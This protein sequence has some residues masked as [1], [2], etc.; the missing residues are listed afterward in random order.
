[1]KNVRSR[2]KQ[3]VTLGRLAF[4]AGVLGWLVVGGAGC[5][6]ES[7]QGSDTSGPTA[8]DVPG[9]RSFEVTGVIR[10]IPKEGGTLLVRHEAIPGYM[11]KMTMEL[12]LLNTQ[13]VA[14]LA[15]GDTIAFRLVARAEDHFIDRVRRMGPPA[16]ATAVA[17]E[18]KPGT[19][20][21]PV[22]PGGA[23]L[24]P[25]DPV[26][27]IAFRLETGE[28]VQISKWRGKAV[29][30]TFIFT[31]CPLPDFCPRMNRNFQEARELLA[32]TAGAPTHWMFLSLSFDSDFDQPAVLK[33]YASQYRETGVEG[34]LF[35]VLGP[36]GVAMVKPAFDLMIGREAGGFSHNLRTV[37]VDPAGKVFR[38]FDGNR[39]TPQDLATAMTEA[40]QVGVPTPAPSGS[41]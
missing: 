22:V 6:P 9:E 13:E 41:L 36:S 40:C 16:A 24:K 25:G 1:M 20:A 34:W 19:E 15:V 12:S 18:T 31:R 33:T 10:E 23:A 30:L 32:S 39:W 29:A 21:V 28:V 11:P 3:A 8:P 26:P 5:G 7:P 2:W 27:E 4:G 35:G 38:Q 37:V 17:V 14:G